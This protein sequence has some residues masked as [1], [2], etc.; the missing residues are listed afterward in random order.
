MAKTCGFCGEILYWPAIYTCYYCQKVY[1]DNH[2]LAEHHQC[3]KVAAARHIEK[4]WLRKKGVNI[5]A[6][7]YSAVCKQCGYSSEYS[8]IEQANQIR[9]EH[10]RNN[11]CNSNLVQLREHDEDRKADEETTSNVNGKYCESG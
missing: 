3:P 2:R 10:I 1:C 11:G 9:I 6:G 8:D 5:T 7:R 4:D